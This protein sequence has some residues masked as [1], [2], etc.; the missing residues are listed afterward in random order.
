MASTFEAVS[1]M[2]ADDAEFERVK[3]S[4]ISLR[5]SLRVVAVAGHVQ[6]IYSSLEATLETVVKAYGMPAPDGADWHRALLNLAAASEP[7]MISEATL[8][9]MNEL[10]A[11]RHAV[12]VKYGSRLDERAL[13]HR[14][15]AERAARMLRDDLA[16]F[17]DAAPEPEASRAGKKRAKP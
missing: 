10:R 5:D 6:G 16:K 2:N 3:A 1:E 4:G 12:R 11:F 14:E 7:P 15:R 8:Q 9:E 13:P 17:L